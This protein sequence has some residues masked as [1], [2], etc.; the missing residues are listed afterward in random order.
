MIVSDIKA[1]AERQNILNECH[2]HWAFTEDDDEL[3]FCFDNTK[4]LEQAR[5]ILRSA[6]EL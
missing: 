1:T 2:I 3:V 6:L 5:N 4:T